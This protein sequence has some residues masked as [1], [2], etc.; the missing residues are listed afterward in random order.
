MLMIIVANYILIFVFFFAPILVS[1][2]IQRREERLMTAHLEQKRLQTILDELDGQ[3][4]G[5]R[6]PRLSNPAGDL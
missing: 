2:L 5:S 4:P 6:V 3:F 1:W